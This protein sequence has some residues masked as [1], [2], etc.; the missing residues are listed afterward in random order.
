MTEFVGHSDYS[1]AKSLTEETF[2]PEML[3]NI[4]STWQR[5]RNLIR[6][7]CKERNIRWLCHF[8]DAANLRSLFNNGIKSRKSLANESLEHSRIDA[9]SKLYFEDFNYISITSPNTK[10]LHTK[11]MKG[12]WVAVV[13][14]DVKLLWEMP[15][16]SIPMNS[17]KSQMR[18]LMNTDYMQFLGHLGLR[19]LFGNHEL[20]KKCKV[21]ISEPT[22]IQ[23]EL[24]FL[25]T[26][27]NNYFRHVWLSPIDKT[28]PIF[29]SVGK[30]FGFFESGTK[31]KHECKWLTRETIDSWGPQYSAEAKDCYNLRKWNEDW[32]SNG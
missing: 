12:I 9:S 11:Y 1:V 27:S 15:F 16:F 3:S 21:P 28:S 24:I 10:M 13:M 30:D 32:N 20:R 22:D 7:F 4:N 26:I 29:E 23:S 2:W 8:S 14:M 17:A 5:D 31:A 6:Q 18:N 19:T 25:N